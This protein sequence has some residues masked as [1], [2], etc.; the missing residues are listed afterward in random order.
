LAHGFPA[1]GKWY[2]QDNWHQP[3]PLPY[4]ARTM[5]PSGNGVFD[6]KVH[7]A[8][9]FSRA[10]IRMDMD[11][12]SLSQD[13]LPKIQGMSGCGIWKIIPDGLALSDW[14]PE[15]MRL[16]GIQHRCKH[17]EYI[18][19]TQIRWVLDRLCKEYPEIESALEISYRKGY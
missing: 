15:H 18:L 16:V 5:V 11:V 8:L 4:F 17:D 9:T 6:P 3:K 13:T 10:A 2:V 19:G 7:L 12:K 1:D 14:N